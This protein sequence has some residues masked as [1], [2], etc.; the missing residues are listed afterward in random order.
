MSGRVTQ[1]ALVVATSEPTLASPK[2]TQ[3]AI[4]VAVNPLISARITQAALVVAYIE[5]PA[6]ASRPSSRAW[7]RGRPSSIPFEA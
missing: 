4:V 5:P 3:A 2:I 1:A 7:R 6:S